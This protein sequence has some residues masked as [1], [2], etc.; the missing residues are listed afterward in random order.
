MDIILKS[1][2]IAVDVPPKQRHNQPSHSSDSL[3]IISPPKMID[4][5]DIPTAT[6]I[7]RLHRL[8]ACSIEVGDMV[9]IASLIVN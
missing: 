8:L 1:Q 7:N 9:V 6:S 5:Y 3:L 4:G 2:Q